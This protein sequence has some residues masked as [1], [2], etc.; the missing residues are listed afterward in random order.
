MRFDREGVVQRAAEL[1]ANDGDWD[2]VLK[3][4]RDDGFSKIE[5]ILAIRD[6]EKIPTGEA[7]EMVHFSS[8]WED[9]REQDEQFHDDL[10]EAVEKL[11]WS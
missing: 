11:G 2:A 3:Q 6:I 5:C 7:K 8:A 4:L 1:R 9:R 10:I